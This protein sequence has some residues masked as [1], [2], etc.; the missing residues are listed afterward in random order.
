MKKFAYLYPDYESEIVTIE[1]AEKRRKYNPEMYEGRTY[2]DMVLLRPVVPRIFKDSHSSSFVFKSSVHNQGHKNGSKGIA[3]DLVQQFIC[4]IKNEWTFKLFQKCY[5]IK[6]QF[7]DYEFYIYDEV[8]KQKRFIDC[9]IHLAEDCP[10]YE[11]FDGK[12][13]VEVTDTSK[14]KY[15]KIST[16][17]R[18]KLNVLELKTIPDWHIDNKSQIEVKE[19]MFLRSRIK[20]FLEKEPRLQSLHLNRFLQ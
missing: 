2:Y 20:G 12:I 3:H 13:G 18:L 19:V 14:T 6:V 17:K 9:M 10:Y 16:L 11:I 7:I 5:T 8:L 1:E 15:L 4:Q